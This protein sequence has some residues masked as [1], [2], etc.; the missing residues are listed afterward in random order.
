M[1][2]KPL[3]VKDM[4]DQDIEKF[5]SES[6]K[7]LMSLRFNY[8]V[9]RHIQNPARISLLK[10]GIAKALTFKREKEIIALGGKKKVKQ[11]T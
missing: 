11:N 7:E 6:R 2:N 8:A 9:S 3:K 1:S 10:K 5:L 4:S